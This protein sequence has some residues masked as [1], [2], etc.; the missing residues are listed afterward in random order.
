MCKL[1]SI[2]N[3][4]SVKLRNRMIPVWFKQSLYF[5]WVPCM[6]SRSNSDLILKNTGFLFS[7][8]VYIPK[9]CISFGFE[10]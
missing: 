1:W 6:C 5:S 2:N 7:M 10:Y 4:M 9:Q 8:Y 3:E